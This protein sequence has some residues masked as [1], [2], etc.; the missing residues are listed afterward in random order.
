[1][2]ARDDTGTLQPAHERRD[3]SGHELGLGT[4]RADPD[5]RV[6]RVRVDIRYRRK[7]QV[8]PRF[9]EIGAQRSRD[10][11]RERDVV[12][13]AERGVPGVRASR[14]RAESHSGGPPCVRGRRETAAPTGVP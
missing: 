11:F 5:H 7:V 8:H 9:R 4:E 3:V 13:F 1:M 12:D 10:V 14:R 2:R 6:Q